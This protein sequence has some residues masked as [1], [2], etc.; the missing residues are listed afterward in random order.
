MRHPCPTIVTDDVPRCVSQLIH[1]FDDIACCRAFAVCLVIFWLGW[2]LRAVAVAA[3]VGC[4]ECVSLG[5]FWSDLV[6]EHVRL[7]IAVQQQDGIPLPT[8]NQID[9]HTVGANTS[10]LES[11]EHPLAPPDLF[12]ARIGDSNGSAISCGIQNFPRYDQ[13]RRHD[14][15]R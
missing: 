9:L 12:A 3:K 2:W 1:H 15:P 10:S 5:E 8:G 7:R 4:D 14:G 11:L 6:P 13:S